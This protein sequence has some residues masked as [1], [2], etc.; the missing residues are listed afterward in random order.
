MKQAL[1]TFNAGSS[2]IKFGL[3]ARDSLTLLCRGQISNIGAD[4]VFTVDGTL[5]GQLRA[6]PVPL[7]RSGDH[8]ALTHWLLGLLDAALAGIEVCAAGHRVVHGGPEFA[9]P[10]RLTPA[11]VEKL[12]EYSA[13][14]PNHQPH[15]LAPIRSV[16]ATW[17]RVIQYACFDT[18]FH[19]TQPR[20]AELFALPRELS[21]AGIIR[22]GFHG[23]SYAYIAGVLPDIIGDGAAAGK[24]IVAHLGHG[25]S[26]CAMVDRRSVGT[27]MGF[28]ALDGLVMGKRCGALDPGVV[29]HLVQHHGMDIDEVSDVLMNKSG[30]LGVSGISDDVRELLASDSPQA[31]EAID[32]FVYRAVRE[33]GALI[34]SIG[35]LDTLVFTAGIGERSAVIRERIAQQF[36]WLGVDIDIGAN[37]G[38]AP[39]I[40]SAR[41][42]VN[43]L[44]I[45]TNEEIV[46]A[47]AAAEFI[48]RGSSANVS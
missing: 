24:V 32:L 39:I 16:A 33:L 15:N 21:D 20:V 9:A 17:P 22:Y 14:A 42:K 12:M 35:G 30:L 5:A 7:P 2:S 36:T 41:S 37:V 29:L 34:A 11:V 31:A 26:L 38:Q 10:T 6:H 45:P 1:L 19:R 43:V 40:N 3:Y 4:A 18:A 48:E 23:L 44:A 8:D 46:I 28:T 47:E 25:A 27:S 13:L